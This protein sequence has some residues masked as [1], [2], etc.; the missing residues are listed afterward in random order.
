MI[1]VVTKF[2]T[3]TGEPV[4]LPW[5]KPHQVALTTGNPD[6]PVRVLEPL[7]VEAVSSVI[8]KK[9]VAGSNGKVYSITIKD[10]KAIHCTCPGFNYRHTCKHIGVPYVSTE[11]QE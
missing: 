6:F 11:L 1:T 7:V 10:S 4:K 9:K 2:G 8:L 3:Y 5:L